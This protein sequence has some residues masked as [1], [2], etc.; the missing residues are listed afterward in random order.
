MK[1]LY[2]V[3]TE[4]GESGSCNNIVYDLHFLSPSKL[5]DTSS[6]LQNSEMFLPTFLE[7]EQDISLNE[8]L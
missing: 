6:L 8:L 1:L 7:N 5:I 3:H 2:C 4:A